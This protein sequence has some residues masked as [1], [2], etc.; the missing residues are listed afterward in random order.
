MID[1]FKQF[2]L[3]QS[4]YLSASKKATK[5]GHHN[6]SD[7]FDKWSHI[8]GSIDGH[9]K[10]PHELGKFNFF[11]RIFEHSKAS[12]TGNNSISYGLPVKKIFR[13]NMTLSQFSS[14]LDKIT[15]SQESPIT[16]YIT[17]INIIPDD[18]LTENDEGTGS[19]PA[20]FILLKVIVTYVDSD[21]NFIR[22][23][24]IQP[25]SSA[26]KIKIPITWYDN[27]F[28]ITTAFDV[29]ID[30][31]VFS[32]RKSAYKF[33]K[34]LSDIKKIYP[35]EFEKIREYFMEYSDAKEFDK[36]LN[37]LKTIPIHEFYRD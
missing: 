11:A 13:G 5:Y 12:Y 37:L 23:M 36:M 4:T 25:D 18:E 8:A 27:E 30:G 16:G 35:G 9:T 29:E 15:L 24:N 1:N 21:N 14:T 19:E 28:E 26:F 20:E 22:L 6:K 31:I 34:V 32:D 33:K 10:T 2:E 3:K 7:Q 17:A